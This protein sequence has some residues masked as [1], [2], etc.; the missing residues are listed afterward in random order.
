M[1]AVPWLGEYVG[2]DNARPQLPPQA[3]SF[4]TQTERWARELNLCEILSLWA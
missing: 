3:L 2:D 1:L 4:Q